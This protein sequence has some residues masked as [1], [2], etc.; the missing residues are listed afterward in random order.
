MP[1]ACL[2][3]DVARG[4]DADHASAEVGW[5][6]VRL[7][8]CRPEACKDESGRRLE[9]ITL[10]NPATVSSVSGENVLIPALLMIMSMSRRAFRRFVNASSIL[11][12]SVMS[13]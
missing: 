11:A 1:Y 10:S 3:L 2:A 9:F 13:V 4:G 6:G 12:G 7:A 5:E 8:M